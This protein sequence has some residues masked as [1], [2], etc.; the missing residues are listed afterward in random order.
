MS[1]TFIGLV[2]FVAA[3][4]AAGGF[5]TIAMVLWVKGNFYDSK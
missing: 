2:A 3:V 5:A 4:I 1:E